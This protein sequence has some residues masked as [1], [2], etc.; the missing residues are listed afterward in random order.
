MSN[1]ATSQVA[2]A[3]RVLK[4]PTITSVCADLADTAREEGW[5]Y[6]E[7]ADREASGIQVRTRAARF[8]QI[9]TLEDFNV[10]HQPILRGRAGGDRGVREDGVATTRAVLFGCFPRARQ[11]AVP[12]GG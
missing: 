8:P 1:D 5:T 12:K 6:E 10:D 7:F 3:A 9:K 4:A 11:C 2:Y